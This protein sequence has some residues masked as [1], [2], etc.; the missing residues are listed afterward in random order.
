MDYLHQ[1]VLHPLQLLLGLSKLLPHHPL[2]L[3]YLLAK[4]LVYLLRILGLD[5]GLGANDVLSAPVDQQ[6]DEL[7]VS[8]IGR[9][10][11]LLSFD[12]LYDLIVNEFRNPA[13]KVL[14]VEDFSADLPIQLLFAQS[15]LLNQL[16]G[17][18]LPSLEVEQLRLWIHFFFYVET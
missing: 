7:G 17:R 9:V 13:L 16:L 8:S 18:L 2:Q 14:L 4:V 10:Q 5:D 12:L 6:K 11:Q 3:P 1:P 15:P